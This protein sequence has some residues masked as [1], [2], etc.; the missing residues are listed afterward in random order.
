MIVDS[1]LSKDNAEVLIWKMI[2]DEAFMLDFLQLGPKDLAAYQALK[3]EKRK[4]EYLGVRAALMTILGEYENLEYFESGKPFLKNSDYQIS[5]SHTQEWL[6]LIVHRSKKVG[7][8]IECKSDKIE[9]LSSRF[10][11]RDEQKYL[12]GEQLNIAWSAKEALYKIVGDEAVDF[13]NQQCL[14]A[15]ELSSDRG[16]FEIRHIPTNK[17]YIGNF[18]LT[19]SYSLVYIVSD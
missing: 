14:Q 2:D 8:D 18:I 3:S 16:E 12:S 10:L 15:F 19:D 7:I 6:A 5:I 11:G 1:F 13:A 9:R 17:M 4:R